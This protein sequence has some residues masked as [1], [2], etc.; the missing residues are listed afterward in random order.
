MFK[1]V[2]YNL[3]VIV[4]NNLQL[5]SFCNFW[6]A[7]LA[8][9]HFATPWYIFTCN[10]VNNNRD[11]LFLVGKLNVLF[12]SSHFFVQDVPKL[13]LYFVLPFVYFGH[14]DISWH[15]DNES[16]HIK[17]ITIHVINNLSCSNF[18]H[19]LVIFTVKDKHQFILGM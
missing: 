1:P 7:V 5:N 11:H 4:F 15:G 19:K 6:A 3:S 2:Y 8:Q 16:C 17:R 12:N 18:C 9:E 10:L 14:L 13:P